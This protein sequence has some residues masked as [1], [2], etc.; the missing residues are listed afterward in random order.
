M[1]MHIIIVFDR[2]VSFM[3][4]ILVTYFDEF[5]ESKGKVTCHIQSRFSK[6]MAKK[7]ETVSEIQYMPNLVHAWG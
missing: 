4:R 1:S 2:L 5:R 3:H 7:S 6:E